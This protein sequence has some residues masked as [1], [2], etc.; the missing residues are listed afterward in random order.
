M[1]IDIW[2]SMEHIPQ[3]LLVP[4]LVKKCLPFKKPQRIQKFQLADS[5][6]IHL[7]P[8]HILKCAHL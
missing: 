2:K 7:N 4:H 3:K 5:T 1:N 6:L 8:F